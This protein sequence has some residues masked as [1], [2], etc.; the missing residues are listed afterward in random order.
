MKKIDWQSIYGPETDEL[1]QLVATALQQ[2]EKPMKRKSLSAILIAALLIIALT[3]GALAVAQKAGLLDWITTYDPQNGEDGAAVVLTDIP[4]EGGVAERGTFTVREAFYDGR[5]M[6]LLVDATPTNEGDAFVWSVAMNT[7]YTVDEAKKFG[8]TLLGIAMHGRITNAGVEDLSHFFLRQEAGLAYIASTLLPEGVSPE[9]LNVV[10]SFSILD[11]KTGDILEETTIT[12]EIPK[13]AEPDIKQF[14]INQDYELVHIDDITISRTPVELLVSIRYKPLLAVFHSFA[15]IPDDGLVNYYR[16]GG[17]M[18][19]Y[20][21][22]TGIHT[23]QFMLPAGTGI[24]ETIPLWMRGTE[25]A[26]VINTTTGEVTIRPVKVESK[27]GD[28]I[29]TLSDE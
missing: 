1:W 26:L 4:Q 14:D 15:S 22:E 6:R 27:G 17:S 19:S 2:E 11:S 5:T 13:T 16:V 18:G 12:C 10:L 28:T 29:V 7:R 8:D 21:Y 25:E 23:G 20:D 3:A 9:T 24:P